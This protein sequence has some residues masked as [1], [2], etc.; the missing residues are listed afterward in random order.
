MAQSRNFSEQKG[1]V[2]QSCEVGEFQKER[3]HKLMW[4]WAWH[5][6]S[7]ITLTLKIFLPKLHK[8]YNVPQDIVWVK[9][10][11]SVGNAILLRVGPS[12]PSCIV[13]WNSHLIDV[14][15]FLTREK[16]NVFHME[17]LNSCHFLFTLSCWKSSREIRYLTLGIC[18]HWLLISP[19][20]CPL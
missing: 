4:E 11:H 14:A 20:K 19:A 1:R 12:L 16:G 10:L 13:G 15:R 3:W 18:L 17:I 6:H 8:K 5:V 2:L 7:Y 9:V